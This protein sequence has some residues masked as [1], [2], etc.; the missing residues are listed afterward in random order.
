M[1]LS[2][3]AKPGARETSVIHRDDGTYL[4]SVTEPPVQGRANQAI[5][6]ALADHFGVSRAQVRI[7][8]G[9]TARSKIV[10]IV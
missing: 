8:S 9:F 7:V 6:R 4:V 10:E 3:R 5:I 1:M 2:I